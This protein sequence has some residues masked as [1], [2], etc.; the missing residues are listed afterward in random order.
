MLRSISKQSKEYVES[1]MKK[2]KEG[3]GIRWEN[4]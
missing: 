4:I 2:K 1:V 3:Y